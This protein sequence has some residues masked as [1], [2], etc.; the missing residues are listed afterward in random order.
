MVEQVNRRLQNVCE[1]I[2]S[3]I[4]DTLKQHYI[5]SAELWFIGL[6]SKLFGK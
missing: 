5:T 6:L 2:D 3:F 1:S 4:N